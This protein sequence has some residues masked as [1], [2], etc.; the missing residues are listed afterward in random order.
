MSNEFCSDLVI[1]DLLDYLEKERNIESIMEKFKLN[2]IEIIAIVK[3][4][5]DEGYD[6]II[7]KFDD[8]LHILNH[9][10]YVDNDS[11]F[12]FETDNNNEFKFVVISDTRLGSKSEQLA[13]LN[14][15]YRKAHEMGIKNVILCGNISAG[16]KPMTDTESNFIDDTQGQIDY[17]VDNYPKYDDIKTYFISGRLDD[18]HLTKNKINIGKRISDQRNDL[19]Y[20]GSNICDLN[21]DKVNM[22]IIN[23]RLNKTYTCSY[24]T[25]QTIDAYRSEDKPDILLYG[26]LM[27]MEKYTHRG[28][29]CITAPSVCATDDEMKAKR[30][31]NT[32]G[33]WYVTVKTNEKGLLESVKAINSPYYISNKKDYLSTNINLNNTN[34]IDIDEKDSALKLYNY[35]KNGMPIE[36]FMYKFKISERELQG[37]LYIW[38]LFGKKIEVDV[39][40]GVPVFKKGYNKKINYNKSSFED[41]TCNEILAVSDT[42]I[43]N[44]NS[45]LHLLNELYKEA[46]NRGVKVVLNIGDLTDGNYPNRPENPRLQTLHGYDEQVGYVINMY[47]YIDGMKT[48]YI[49]GSH[50]E[51]HYKNGQATVDFALNKTRK[52]MIY[53][54]QDIGEI[55]IDKVKYVLDHPGGGSAQGLSYKPQKRIEIMESHYKPNVLLIGHYHKSYHFLYRNVQCI[56]VPSLCYKTQF[57]QKQGISNVVG[58]YFIKVYSDSKGNIQYFEPEEILFDSKDQ[59]DEFGKDKKKVKKLEIKNGIY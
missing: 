1:E 38:N 31:S 32:I 28:V 53:L 56:E 40:D 39:V 58:G 47:P 2:E 4:L 10:D 13:I 12:K 19:I 30:Y 14:D 16:L 17:I 41:L 11:K 22:Q 49:L 59:W 37:L 50:D 34:K 57:Q 3:D 23:S 36:T 29:N 51:T 15:I 7:K 52:D 54:G 26:G 55:N 42:H 24:R 25:Q 9:G 43:G 48:Y 6:I 8:G 46:Y 35:A 33:A 27:Q 21:I 18:K 20:L 5:I 45:Q 44:K